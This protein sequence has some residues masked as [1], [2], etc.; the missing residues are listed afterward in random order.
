LCKVH[1][2]NPHLL[3]N[4]LTLI[5]LAFRFLKLGFLNAHFGLEHWLG[6]IDLEQCGVE[7]PT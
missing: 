2:Q 1:P 4:H 5:S 3:G 7:D 6:S